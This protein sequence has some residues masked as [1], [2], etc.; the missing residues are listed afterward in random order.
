MFQRPRGTRDF[1]PEEMER[2]RWIEGKMRECAR[3]WGYREVC[4]P[5]FEELELFTLRSG[6]AIVQE[7]YTFRDKGGRDLVLRPEITAP[8]I[9]MFVN[10]GKN[11]PRPIRWCYFADCFRYERPQKGRYRQF[12]QFGVE[13][14]GADTPGA[15]AEAIALGDAILRETGVRFEMKV[16]HLAPMK[17]MLGELPGERRTK[18]MQ[19]LD[20]RNFEGLEEYLEEYGQ[21]EL[22]GRLRALVSCTSLDDLFDLCG[23][24]QEEE[25]IRKVFQELELRGTEC[26][27]NF[28]IARG[29]DYYTGTV[30]EAFAE[31]LGAENQI[32]GGGAYR[33]AQLFGGE[34]VASCGFAVGFDRV[35]VA[36]GEFRVPRQP[37]VA[38]VTTPG[39]QDAAPQI[40][41]AFRRAGIRAEEDLME[42]NFGA[43]LSH[44]AKF[45]DY[46][47]IVGRKELERGAVS[48]RDL[49]SGEQRELTLEQAIEE[50]KR[51]GD[52]G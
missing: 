16:G 37:V 29:L 1:L 20:R 19:L 9:R 41:G 27:M 38:I 25:R 23:H 30:F 26:T 6:E 42:R 10:E 15:D 49:K 39:A 5:T 50:V 13:L 8:V 35:M 40:A 34:D 4:T 43:Q 11:L 45:A 7:M 21:T 2:R 12:W 36:L 52:C 28:G 48:L 44:A 47:V 3:R 46:A 24:I 31:N 51:V 22:Y 33:L 32:L 17:H 18:V 14:I